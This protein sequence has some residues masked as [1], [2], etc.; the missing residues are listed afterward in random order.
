MDAAHFV[1]YDGTAQEM[2]LGV[3]EFQL[4]RALMEGHVEFLSE[5]V[6]SSWGPVHLFDLCLTFG[7]FDTAWAMAE[8]GVK[9]CRLEAHHLQ[10]DFHDGDIDRWGCSNCIDDWETCEECCFGFPVE[11]GIWMTGWNSNLSNA[12][13]A[14]RRTAD[15]SLMDAAYAARRAAEQPLNRT[16]LEALRSDSLPQSL[17]TWHICWTSPS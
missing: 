11:Q 13:N 7:L 4:A 12:A 15:S 10:R 6:P 8:R 17:A 1:C 3:K 9:G 2:V 16:V 14:A 5:H